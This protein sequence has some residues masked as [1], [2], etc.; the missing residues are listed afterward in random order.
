MDKFNLS[1][2][3]GAEYIQVAMAKKTIK[4]EYEIGGLLNIFVDEDILGPTA[5]RYDRQRL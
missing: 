4:W 1:R 5:G 3:I 2:R